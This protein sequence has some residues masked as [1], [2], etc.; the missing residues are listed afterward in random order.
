MSTY[1][2]ANSV[3]LVKNHLTNVDFDLANSNLTGHDNANTTIYTNQVHSNIIMVKNDETD[4][5]IL[6]NDENKLDL[7]RFK[8]A[9]PCKKVK[10][11]TGSLY[12]HVHVLESR[13]LEP[14]NSGYFII[15]EMFYSTFSLIF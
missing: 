11:S 8:T 10:N 7:G 4:A 3:I 5:S 12:N 13:K 2:V 15:N 9:K 14:T 6:V 1:L